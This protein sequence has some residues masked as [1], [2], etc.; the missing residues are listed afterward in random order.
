LR[1]TFI[2]NNPLELRQTRAAIC[3]GAQR[4]PDL[5]YACRPA[6]CK[7]CTNDIQADAETGADERSGVGNAF[8]R[9]A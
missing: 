2:T 1:D 6:A 8:G 9:L 3:A 7:R 5:F 4:N